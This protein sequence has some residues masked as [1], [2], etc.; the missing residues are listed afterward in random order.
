MSHGLADNTQDSTL[1]KTKSGN[2]FP[3]SATDW[4]WWNARVPGRLRE[5]NSEGYDR[6][7]FEKKQ[8]SH[9]PDTKS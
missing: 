8:S 6:F 1:I 7:K 2:V 9:I 4:Q 3:K 5:L